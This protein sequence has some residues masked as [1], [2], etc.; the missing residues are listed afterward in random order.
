MI[1]ENNTLF[2]QL[3]L[4][5][6]EA[7]NKNSKRIDELDTLKILEII[8]NEDKTV[9][10][11]VEKELK[12]IAKAVELIVKSFKNGGRLFY[13]GAGTSGR[14]GIID[15]AEMPPTYGTEPSLVQAIIAGGKKTVFRSQ[16][17][18]EDREV[19]AIKNL[20]KLKLS[21][22]DVVCGI[23]ASLRTPFVVAALAYAKSIGAKTIL[24]STNSRK[25]LNDKNFT[26]LKK[27]IDVAICPEVGPEVIA[28][29]TRMK[30]GTAQ[31]MVLNMLTTASMIR[32]GKVY[33]NLMV[34]LKMNSRKLEERAKRIIML[35]T[36]VDY[37]T[38][39]TYLRKSGGNVKLALIMITKKVSRA[40]AMRRLK[41]ANGF[42]RLALK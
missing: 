8:N 12:Y 9:A 31:K 19:E 25:L 10:Y 42:V 41:K 39:D 6:T 16:E 21:D 4:L 20:R 26:N 32:I 3:Q 40:E 17:G 22:Q 15:A 7:Q 14:L 28:G 24:I 11:S 30:S 13:V 18:V 29:S 37:D 36:G 5:Q 33:G 27:I 38:A 35:I 34:D 1:K 23:A 2:N